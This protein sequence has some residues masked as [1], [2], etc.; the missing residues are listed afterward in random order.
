MEPGEGPGLNDNIHQHPHSP[1]GSSSHALT[2]SPRSPR[3]PG[4]PCVEQSDELG[5]RGGLGQPKGQSK[6]GLERE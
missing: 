3:L 4:G 2:F 1:Q 5:D 6:T